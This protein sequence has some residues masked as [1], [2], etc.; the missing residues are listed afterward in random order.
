[1]RRGHTFVWDFRTL[2]A[3]IVAAL[4]QIFFFYERVVQF[5]EGVVVNFAILVRWH[6]NHFELDIAVLFQSKKEYLLTFLINTKNEE[7]F[8]RVC[9]HICEHID[10]LRV[11]YVF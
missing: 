2:L 5:A 11:S 6:E 10:R 1:M 4:E 9:Y 3:R 7:S 8:R